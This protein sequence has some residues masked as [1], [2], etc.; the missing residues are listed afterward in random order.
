ML[1]SWPIAYADYIG[2]RGLTSEDL[3]LSARDV[4]G[5]AEAR[6]LNGLNM[7]ALCTIVS[8]GGFSSA[9]V[10]SRVAALVIRGM[11][12]QLSQRM[13]APAPDL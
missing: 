11:A 5:T 6:T 13:P 8:H 1:S 3:F 12:D 10:R 9:F 2:A 4:A 7:A